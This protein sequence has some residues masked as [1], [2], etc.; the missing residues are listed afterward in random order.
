M[1]AFV[2]GRN[3][4]AAPE[5][6]SHNRVAIPHVESSVCAG[7]VLLRVGTLWQVGMKGEQPVLDG[8]LPFSV[9]TD[10]S[11]WNLSDTKDGRVLEVSPSVFAWTAAVVVSSSAASEW[12][13]LQ[14]ASQAIPWRSSDQDPERTL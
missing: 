11:V 14:H 2:P 7:W 5:R 1:C 12:C 4:S 6:L 10:D 3:A 13:L 9:K 8:E